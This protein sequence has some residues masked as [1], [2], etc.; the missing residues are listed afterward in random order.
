VAKSD[1]VGGA[2]VIQHGR[3]VEEGGIVV[4]ASLDGKKLA[5]GRK[6]VTTALGA[7]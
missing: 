1:G 4:F 2:P 3:E 7:F 5:Q 6:E